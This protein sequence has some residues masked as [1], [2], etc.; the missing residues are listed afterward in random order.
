MAARP[1]MATDRPEPISEEVDMASPATRLIGFL[2]L[3]V[4]MFAGAFAAGARLGP[5]EL[6]HAPSAPGGT[7]HMN[8][9]SGPAAGRTVVPDSGPR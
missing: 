4:I 3:L 8:M 5:V 1:L 6:T 7:M 9:G 2:L